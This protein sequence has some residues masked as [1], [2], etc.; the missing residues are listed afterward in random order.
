MIVTVNICIFLLLIANV[1]TWTIGGILSS[2]GKT[3]VDNTACKLHE[4]CNSEYIPQNMNKLR[5]NLKVS[6]YGQHIVQEILFNALHDHITNDDPQKALAIS[7]HGAPGIGKNYVTKFIVESFYKLGFKSKYVHFYYGPSRFPEKERVKIYQME[8][9]REIITAL[10]NCPNQIF[11][12]DEIDKMPRGVLDA[13]KVFLDTHKFIEQADVRRAIFIFILNTGGSDIV[14]I[15]EDKKNAGFHREQL[16][17]Y[18]FE[19]DLFIESFNK[20]GGFLFA[21]IVESHLIDHYIPFLPLDRKH[22][23]LCIKDEFQLRGVYRPTSDQIKEIMEYVD[24][25]GQFASAGCKRISAK[26][27]SVIR[28][29]SRPSAGEL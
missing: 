27:G 18:H 9:Y 6:L 14:R 3:F 13:L 16:K 4:C 29:F 25:D 15:Y 12:F 28:R 17:L 1:H 24:F 5:D 26:V 7:F 20:A 10:K 23:E 19:R 8:L 2:I 21:D 11:I 22:V